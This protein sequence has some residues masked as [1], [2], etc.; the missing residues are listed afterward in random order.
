MASVTEHGSAPVTSPLAACR[1][2]VVK[3]GSA[4]L[5][6]PDGELRCE[7]LATLA[8]DIAEER[9]AGRDVVVVSSGA[10]ALGRGMLGLGSGRLALEQAQA[11]AA[12]GQMRLARAWEEAL[13]PHGHRTAQVLV[14]LEDTQNR[15]RYLNGRATLGTLIRYGA[16]PVVNENDTVATDEIR[17]G[18]NDRLAARVALMAGA[19]VL[20]LLSDVDGLYTGNPREVPDARHLPHVT[21][22][23]P[24]IEAMAGGAGSGLSRGGMR[25]KVLA[26][27]TAIQGGCAM[28]IAEGARPHPLRAIREGARVTWFHAQAT[29]TAARKKWIAG[30]KAL[31]A[32]TVDAGA[33]EALRRGKSLLSAGVRSISGEF[34]RGDPVSI[35]AESGESIGAALAG[36]NSTEAAAIAGVRS[37]RIAEV[38]GYDG[39]AALVH[40]DDLVIWGM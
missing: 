1:R 9:L 19:D 14:T 12:V 34:Q 18:D 3:V 25:T 37:E 16:V 20:V 29:P 22:I 7:W 32:M 38:L 11:A 31:G 4:L 27:K 5:V 13:S 36:Y 23:T 39:R 33:V 26:A 24:E 21:E 10:I 8:A 28:A 6:A 17:Y 15:R 30:M 2:L 35:L 40:R